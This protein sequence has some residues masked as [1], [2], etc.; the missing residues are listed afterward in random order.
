MDLPEFLFRRV[1]FLDLMILI[2]R[3]RHYDTSL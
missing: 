2:N 1:H 3:H